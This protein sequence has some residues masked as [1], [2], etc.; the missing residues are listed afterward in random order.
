MRMRIHMCMI[1]QTRTQASAFVLFPDL[2]SACD[3][4]LPLK[5]DKL[6][7]AVELCDYASLRSARMSFVCWL[8]DGALCVCAC[9]YVCC[10][11]TCVAHTH[12][13]PK[14]PGLCSRGR[15]GSPTPTLAPAAPKAGGHAAAA[16]HAGAVDGAGGRGGAADPSQRQ[17]TGAA[18]AS[19]AWVRCAQHTCV[20]RTHKSP[21]LLQGAHGLPAPPRWLHD[22][23]HL[24]T[25]PTP[26]R[27]INIDIINVCRPSWTRPFAR[28]RRVSR[29][30]ASRWAAAAQSQRASPATPSAQSQRCVRG[31]CVCARARCVRAR[32]VQ[33]GCWCAACCA[34]RPGCAAPVSYG[35][36]ASSWSHLWL[37]TLRARLR[38][39]RPSRCSGTSA[40]A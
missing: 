11:Q 40:R 18:A 3:A 19:V 12:L 29:A 34:P 16:A 26:W 5:R 28:R 36:H 24:S 20:Q 6:A 31:V 35:M 14:H 7:V 1:K 22:C 21:L 10:R 25:P 30:A 37:H 4:V 32:C 13:A 33:A 17:H 27:T 15:H 2:K 9:V 8:R 23:Q 38:A 39:C